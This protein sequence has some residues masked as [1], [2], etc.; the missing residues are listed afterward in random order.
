MDF[1]ERLKE[2][3][4]KKGVSQSV[5][6]E[7]AGIHVTNISRYERGENKPTTQVLQKLADC[8]SVSSDYLMGGSLEDVASDISDRELLQQF[9]KVAG[10]PESEKGVVKKLLGAFLFQNEIKEKLA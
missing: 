2:A 3:R 1:K 7:Q 6:A 8:L 9:K 10:L 4:K 5:L